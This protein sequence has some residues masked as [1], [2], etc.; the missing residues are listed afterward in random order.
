MK[1]QIGFTLIEL[2]VTLTVAI[3]LIGIA[4]PSLSSLYEAQRADAE[5][6]KIQQTLQQARNAAISFGVRVTVCPIADNQCSDNWQSGLV[7][8]SDSGTI[9]AI[10]GSD[11]IIFQTGPFSSQ[12]IVS[13]NRS[14]VRFF[15][16][17]LA[18]GSNGTLKYC[19]G[20]ATS[21]NSRAVVVN[22]AGRIRF[23]TDK[24]I[25]CAE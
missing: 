13:Y 15:P 18:S 2:M 25:S 10:D 23:S 22:Q 5:I 19:P 7:V 16:D 1:N 11:K 17:G 9:N 4:A 21:P 24:N 14:S 12:D 8:F 6:R 3:I 20:S